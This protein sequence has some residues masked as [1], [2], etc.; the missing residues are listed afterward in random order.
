[1]IA[2]HG[3]V[4]LARADAVRIERERLGEWLARQRF[5]LGDA[6]DEDDRRYR[7]TWNDAIDHVL[8]EMKTRR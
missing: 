1:V 8:R 2:A 4:V 3:Q 5:N 7:K 6:K